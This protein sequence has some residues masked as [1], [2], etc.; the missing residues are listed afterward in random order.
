MS[1]PQ[2]KEIN[3]KAL[4]FLSLLPKEEQSKVLEYLE[5]LIN[6]QKVKTSESPKGTPAE[7]STVK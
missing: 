4:E 3:Q 1:Q 6:L 5:S 2:N 7:D